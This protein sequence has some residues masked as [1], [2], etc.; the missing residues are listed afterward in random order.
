MA[1]NKKSEVSI[2]A[3]FVLALSRKLSLLRSQ[4]EE[5]MKWRAPESHSWNFRE[6]YCISSGEELE[7]RNRGRVERFI[8]ELDRVDEQAILTYVDSLVAIPADPTDNMLEGIL[9]QIAYSSRK[10]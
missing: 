3:E 8:A 9:T 7:A 1:K 5:Q 4:A 10:L 2:K 6:S